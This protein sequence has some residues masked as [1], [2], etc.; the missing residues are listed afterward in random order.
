MSTCRNRADGFTLVEVMAA[1]A[2]L[3]TTFVVLVGLQQRDVS[4][5][6]YANRLTVATLLARERMMQYEMAGF[7]QTG[8]QAGPGQS[9]SR[10]RLPHS[11]FGSEGASKPKQDPDSA[12]PLRLPATANSSRE[13]PPA[14]KLRRWWIQLLFRAAH[15]LGLAWGR[16]HIYCGFA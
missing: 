6:E 5:Q 13:S 9:Q 10:K 16:D 12:D 4:L 14:D 11:L 1:M 3:A 7:P 2:I 8:E 15:L